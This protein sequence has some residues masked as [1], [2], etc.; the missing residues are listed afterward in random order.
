MNDSIDRR[1]FLL[2][3]GFSIPGAFTGCGRAPVQKAIPYLI[4]PEEI[5][6]GKPYYY[7]STCGACPARCGVLVKNR[8]GRPIKL[9][10]NPDHPLSHGGLCAAGQASILGLYDSHRLKHP[11]IG[12]SKA[13]WAEVDRA[14]VAR[15]A[16]IREKRAAVRFL[17]G[18]VNSP[19]LQSAI[20]AFL[21]SFA[22][23]RHVA[24]DALSHSAILDAHER[25]H[26]VRVLPRYRFDRADVIVSFDA[27]FLGTWVSPVEFTA[28]W[29]TRRTPP[30]M[31]WHAQFESRMSLTGSK[32]DKRVAIDPEE[33]GLILSRLASAV[34]KR[35]G[36]VFRSGEVAS[37]LAA[38]IAQVAD[39]LWAARGRSIVVSGS[40]SPD[41][42]ALVNLI[43]ERLGNYGATIDLDTPSGQ[44]SGSD[45][46][47][48]QL[49]SE[50]NAGTVAALFIHDANPVYDKPAL[51]AAIERVPLVVSF[52]PRLDET[53]ALAHYVCPDR[54][55]LESWGDAEPVSGT[56]SLFQPAIEPLGNTRQAIETIAA[57]SGAPRSAYDA[58]RAHWKARVFPRQQA[59]ED[60][61]QFWKSALETGAV[62]MAPERAAART[63]RADAVTA[64]PARARPQGEFSLV[65][66]AKVG[67]PDSSHAYNPWLQELPD[68]VTK[69]TWDNYACI[70]PATATA[71]GIETGDVVRVEANGRS[72][73]LRAV[74][75]PGQHRNAIAIASG[76][77]SKATARFSKA[78]PQWL[79]AKS[80]VG[81]DGLVG[82]NIATLGGARHV[83][84]T[85]TGR[86]HL[87]AFSQSQPTIS[88]PARL[89]PPDGDRR[90]IIHEFSVDEL[91]HA[92]KHE[93]EQH[94]NLWP[95]DH[96]YPGRRWAMAVD[97]TACTGCSACVLACQVEN[98]VPVVG[99]DEVSRKRGMHWMRIDRYYSGT[100][101]DVRVA[102]QPMMCQQCG[103]APCETVCPVV[104]TVHSAEGLNQQV[105][106]RCVGTRYCENNCPYKAR[107]FNWFDY[108]RDDKL[109]NLVLNPDV[110]VRGRGVMEKCSFCVQRIQ[111]RKIE[112]K[113][114]GRALADG[115]VQTACQQSCPAQAIVF[116]D[117]NDPKSKVAQLAKSNRAYRVLDETNV[118]PSVTYLP[119][120]RN[121][122]EKEHG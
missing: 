71:L 99:K 41:E 53:S 47:L 15:L 35:G 19:A 90:S 49:E 104:A 84:F 94:A 91:G 22:G 46:A 114:E 6:P 106:N 51:K 80:S 5:T 89:V 43:N 50:L 62:E 81:S 8:D 74:I 98:N 40:Q 120:V 27:D 11:L 39:R 12:G 96:R 26:G 115:D 103:N 28:A 70:A 77:G 102:H 4:K 38:T 3:A 87:L 13:T 78:G 63:F 76:Y 110:T 17:S 107:R 45:E 20:D 33:T 7:A 57:F 59:T 83:R 21:A 18:T 42:Q 16:E 1:S 67:M 73:E 65:R 24:Y 118:E 44:R 86:K 32:A 101:D 88:V 48:A 37:T 82:T 100:D 69:I 111:Q 117:V 108:A 79:F 105:Y 29:R 25:T 97:L 2:A 10:G 14:V 54:H 60:F 9:E 85:K 122:S 121:R 36:E 93:K 113:A 61:E 56:V 34:S 72:V 66:Y 92:A 75:Q 31:S 119:L 109:A 30:Q 64:V 55:W 68:P 23:A 95:D 52:A 58:I 112:A 116:G